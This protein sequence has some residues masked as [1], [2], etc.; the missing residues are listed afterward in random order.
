[1]TTDRAGL[2]RGTDQ[3]GRVV[4]YATARSAVFAATRRRSWIGPSRP[5]SAQLGAAPT[6]QPRRTFARARVE[7]ERERR[8]E[9]CF[10]CTERSA[11]LRRDGKYFSEVVVSLTLTRVKEVSDK[12]KCPIVNGI[13]RYVC[14]KLTR[15]KSSRE[16]L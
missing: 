11:F 6:R 14:L 7:A 12:P 15:G 9:R 2:P 8:R 5:A 3:A 13:R 4:W 1:M 16:V 10:F